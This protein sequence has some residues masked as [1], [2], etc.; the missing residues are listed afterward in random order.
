MD[1]G[2]FRQG[3]VEE[4]ITFA[5]AF[6]RSKKRK[7]KF[8]RGPKCPPDLKY[9]W[10]IFN[11]VSDRDRRFMPAGMAVFH[12]PLSHHDLLDY[13]KCWKLDLE[14]WER[15][16]I[17]ALDDK[18]LPIMNEGKGKKRDYKKDGI[19]ATQTDVIL[20]TWTEAAASGKRIIMG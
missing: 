15:K 13:M 14:Y 3:L 16:V 1:A 11:E 10:D 17:F 12:L 18:V 5:E 9:L 19:P 7:V 6:E 4:L 2:A 8:Y 20:A